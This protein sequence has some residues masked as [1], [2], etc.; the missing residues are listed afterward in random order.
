[1]LRFLNTVNCLHRYDVVC[2]ASGR[3]F[4]LENLTPAKPKDFREAC[5]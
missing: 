3:A 5:V 2:Q 1:L 4:D